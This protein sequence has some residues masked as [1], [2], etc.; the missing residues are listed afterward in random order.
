M[1]GLAFAFTSK[2]RVSSP[3]VLMK[4]ARTGKKV[5]F[6]PLFTS[7]TV[8]DSVDPAFIA[9]V[10]SNGGANDIIVQRMC[11]ISHAA[12]LARG[13][14]CQASFLLLRCNRFACAS[15]HKGDLL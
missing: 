13:L 6:A 4:D 1:P 14:C 5:F 12:A 15:A 9:A 11:G 8:A 2:T 10:E 7:T 3:Q